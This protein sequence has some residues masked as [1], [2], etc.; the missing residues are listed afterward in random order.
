[1]RRSIKGIE[2]ADVV[3]ERGSLCLGHIELAEF[4]RQLVEMSSG[5]SNTGISNSKERCGLAI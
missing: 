4:G 2:E 1:M 3:G 5:E